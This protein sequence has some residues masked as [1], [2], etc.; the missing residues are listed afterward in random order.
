MTMDIKKKADGSTLVS[1]KDEMTI[2]KVL[3]HKNKLYPL[4]TPDHELLIDLAEISEMD[5]AGLQLLIFLKKES[6]RIHST[7][8][9]LH[10]S[11]GVV[12]II[13]RLNLSTFF[14]DPIVI[15]ADWNNL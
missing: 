10:H 7:L 14:G 3:E 12:E 2:Y 4:L 15:S 13:E 5:S 9:L 8:S 6:I 1:I 11:Q